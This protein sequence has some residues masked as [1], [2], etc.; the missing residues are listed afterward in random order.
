[1]FQPW[2]QLL[3]QPSN[4]QQLQAAHLVLL[5]HSAILAVLG[6]FEQLQFVHA[7]APGSN[8]QHSST[9]TSTSNRT[10][11]AVASQANWQLRFELPRFS[12]EFELQQGGELLSR[13]HSRFKLSSCQQLVWGQGLDNSS[14]GSSSLA[15]D[16]S[17]SSGSDSCTTT[18]HDAATAGGLAAGR[19]NS[20]GGASSMSTSS[21]GGVADAAEANAAAGDVQYTL[22]DFQQYL[23][24]ERVQCS[25]SSSVVEGSE[26]MVLVPSGQ[27]VRSGVEAQPTIKL[28]KS[29]RSRN[30]VRPPAAAAHSMF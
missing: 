24:L 6:K 10:S 19:S 14:Q 27:V 4:T 12:L 29:A 26:R 8:S 18:G 9:S 13:D 30:Q 11:S 2:Q 15:I 21:S 17:N 5:Q 16:R 23:L 20:A 25:S 3:Q 7:Y 22:L 28:S 1:M